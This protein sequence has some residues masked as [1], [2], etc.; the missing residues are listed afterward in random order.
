MGSLGKPR[1]SA[2]AKQRVWEPLELGR[3]G[4]N[5]SD[6]TSRQ[7]HGSQRR[8]YPGSQGSGTS[9]ERSFQIILEGPRELLENPHPG[10][11]CRHPGQSWWG[12]KINS[13]MQRRGKIPEML[14]L[15]G[16]SPQKTSFNT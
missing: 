11:Q 2:V 14:G 8:G 9:Q 15:V 1:S 5:H 16:K 4:R 6:R 7:D 13:G 12:S 3:Q 10:R